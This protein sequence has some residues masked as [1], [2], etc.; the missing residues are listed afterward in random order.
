MN[1]HALRTGG[2]ALALVLLI[3]AGPVLGRVVPGA[4]SSTGWFAFA[5]AACFAAMALSLDVIAGHAGQLTLGHGALVSIGAVASGVVTAKWNLPFVIGAAAGA[6]IAFVVSWVFA[7]PAVRLGALSLGAVTLAVAI[8]VETSLFRWDWLTA[9]REAMVLPR[10]LA[11]S[12]RFSAAHDYAAIAVATAVGLWLVDRRIGRSRFGRS[13]HVIRDDERMAQALGSDPIRQK[14]RAFALAGA[15]GGIAG[16]VY[17]H[18][19]ITIGSEAFG[20]SRLSL[21][22]LALVVIAGQ[23]SA[24]TV[25]LVGAAYG[26]LPRVI[27]PL[28][29]WIP[30]ASAALFL[31]AVARNPEGIVS[32]V[33]T[34]RRRRRASAARVEPRLTPLFQE[35]E[36][37]HRSKRLALEGLTVRVGE[38][39]LLDDVSMEV[40]PRAIV[41]LVGANGAGKTTA[42]N[43]VSGFIAAE[44]GSV[45]IDGNDLL[46]RPSHQRRALGVART[47]QGGS[48]PGRLDV[49]EALLLFQPGTE[50]EARR[51]A[52]DLA[53]ALGFI[54]R[55]DT[56]MRELSVGQQ[57]L[58][59]LAGVLSSE[60]GFLL[61]DEPS[62]GLAPPLVDELSSY[63]RAVRDELGR[64]VLLVEHNMVLVRAVAD[65]VVVLDRGRVVHDG[66]ASSFFDRRDDEALA[67][68]GGAPA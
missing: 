56:P 67:W 16:S 57:R 44:S 18:L 26:L 40:P 64:S 23:G 53:A 48:L 41:A 47:F 5:L 21:P 2:S 6:I 11:G 50:V 68:L 33:R 27:D 43:A 4:V 3:A 25:A 28:E 46:A 45:T 62:A 32:T 7:R 10:P 14:Q 58:V 38:R 60:A 1:R 37:Q 12:F 9:G 13:L 34:R 15:M 31:N 30:V 55:L 59:E 39:V 29:E 51:S 19:L 63:L 42:L 66:A 17:G 61:L 8:A 24:G 35:V 52:H 54:D 36:G 22:L 49:E 20:F 65:T